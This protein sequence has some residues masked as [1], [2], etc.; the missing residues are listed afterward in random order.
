MD[1]NLEKHASTHMHTVACMYACVC[2]HMCVCVC[3]CMC[4]TCRLC[5]LGYL[6][7]PSLNAIFLFFFTVRQALVCTR[8]SR[9][10]S[11]SLLI[12]LLK[13][14]SGQNSQGQFLQTDHKKK[15]QQKNNNLHKLSTKQT[16]PSYKVLRGEIVVVKQ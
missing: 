11:I 10:I 16:S 4:V 8:G 13:I 2:V 15:Q 3:V 12:L 9:C 6:Y 1:P 14:K 5:L 7:C